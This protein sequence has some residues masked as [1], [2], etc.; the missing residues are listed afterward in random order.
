MKNRLSGVAAAE[1][2]PSLAVADFTTVGAGCEQKGQ[3]EAE[4]RSGSEGFDD[5]NEK[6]VRGCDI[7]I[8]S[9]CSKSTAADVSSTDSVSSGSGGGSSN[10][11]NDNQSD[12]NDNKAATATATATTTPAAAA[13]PGLPEW[14]SAWLADSA[15]ARRWSLPKGLSNLGNTCF[16]NSVLQNIAATRPLFAFVQAASAARLE[17]EAQPLR[18]RLMQ[19]VQ[20]MWEAGAEAEASDDDSDGGGRQRGAQLSKSK[21]GGKQPKKKERRRAGHASADPAPVFNEIA[22]LNPLFRGRHQQV[23]GVEGWQFAGLL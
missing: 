18:R 20:S 17:H 3:G 15:D 23:G 9:T 13:F 2:S 11:S 12:S 16:Y 6:A 4:C 5:N 1:S 19:L 10:Q 21:G 22:R 8:N 14:L 7:D